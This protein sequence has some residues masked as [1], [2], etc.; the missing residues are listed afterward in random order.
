MQPPVTGSGPS[1]PGSTRGASCTAAT[2]GSSLGRRYTLLK[3]CGA[4]MVTRAPDVG[5]SQVHKKSSRCS[6]WNMSRISTR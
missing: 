1:R 6:C 3:T 4:Q 5:C 2:R